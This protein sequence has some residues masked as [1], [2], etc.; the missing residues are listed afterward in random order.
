MQF[1]LHTVP[2]SSL[3]DNTP[4]E[5]QLD[6]STLGS[7]AAESLVMNS[8]APGAADTADL[9]MV[10]STEESGPLLMSGAGGGKCAC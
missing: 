7:L 9:A 1:R 6:R 4:R 5:V 2:P 10:A 3:S 8:H